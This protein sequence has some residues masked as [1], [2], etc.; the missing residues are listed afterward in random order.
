MS[1]QK[2]RDT[3]AGRAAIRSPGRPP[4]ARREH[5]KDFWTA[6]AAGTSSEQA[7]GLAGVSPAVGACW[8]RNAGGMP[9]SQFALSAKPLSGRYLTFAE[10]EEIALLLAQNQ[11]VREIARRLG[12]HASTISREMRRN[13]GTRGHTFTCRAT[14]ALWHADRVARRPKAA[15]LATNDT[16][17]HYVQDR[18][19]GASYRRQA[20]RSRG[21]K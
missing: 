17:R 10:R 2:C 16:L 21:R 14:T 5:L 8:F 6:I 19:S 15:K 1:I 18:L 20:R 7:A 13:A 11:G 3:R 9:P 12:R 4:V